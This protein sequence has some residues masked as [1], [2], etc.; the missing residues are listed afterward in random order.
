MYVSMLI[1]CQ[2]YVGKYFLMIH[3]FHSDPGK[4][5][6]LSVLILIPYKLME[7]GPG[8]EGKVADEE[9]ERQPEVSMTQETKM[10]MS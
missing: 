1:F 5:S 8:T 7:V 4:R 9:N 10:V 6:F 2:F 3:T